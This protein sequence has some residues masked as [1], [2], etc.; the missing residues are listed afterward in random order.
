MLSHILQA[1]GTAVVSSDSTEVLAHCPYHNQIIFAR[2]ARDAFISQ[3][4]LNDFSE[5]VIRKDIQDRRKAVGVFEVMYREDMR[6][7]FTGMGRLFYVA[8]ESF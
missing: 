1:T 2:A 4:G 8:K 5:F 7:N 3:Q 6:M